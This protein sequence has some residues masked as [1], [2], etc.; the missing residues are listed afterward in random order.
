MAPKLRLIPPQDRARPAPKVASQP[1]PG[2]TELARVI[3]TGLV[4]RSTDELGERRVAEVYDEARVNAP[5][6]VT[7]P[8]GV[9]RRPAWAEWVAEEH[10]GTPDGFERR[11]EN[12]ETVRRSRKP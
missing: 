1:A 6:V 8:S 7:R 12:G 3:G 10:A 9:V 2:L 5:V 11:A 4:S